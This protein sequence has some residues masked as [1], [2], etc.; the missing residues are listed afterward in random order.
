MPR[1]SLAPG[2]MMMMRPTVTPGVEDSRTPAASEAAAAVEAWA[3]D[4]DGTAADR[5]V[6]TKNKNQDLDEE[7]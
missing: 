6:G 5:E 2:P 4:D 1:L 3:A 7:R